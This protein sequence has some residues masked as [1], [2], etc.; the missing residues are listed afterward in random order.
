M[1][2]LLRGC[3]L[4]VIEN[5]NPLAAQMPRLLPAKRMIVCARSGMGLAI[6]KEAVDAG[7]EVTIAGA[8]G[9]SRAARLNGAGTDRPNESVD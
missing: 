1:V 5:L 9:D 6:A 4:N 8:C 7:A 3:F 2:A